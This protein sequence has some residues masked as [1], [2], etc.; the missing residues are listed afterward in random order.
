MNG[1][2]S[3]NVFTLL[4]IFLLICLAVRMYNGGRMSPQIRTLSLDPA[5]RSEQVWPT[6]IYPIFR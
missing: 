4:F 3:M 5:A 1:R 2:D 6:R